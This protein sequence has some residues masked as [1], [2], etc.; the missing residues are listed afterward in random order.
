MQVDKKTEKLV[1]TT[2]ISRFEFQQSTASIVLILKVLSLQIEFKM[3]RFLSK[4]RPESR[5][6][7]KPIYRYRD[8]TPVSNMYEDYRL[9]GRSPVASRSSSYATAIETAAH[10]KRSEDL[11]IEF[12]RR[13]YQDRSLSSAVLVGRI[14]LSKLL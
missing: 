14:F 13:R 9:F 3:S 10:S 4:Y 2:H 6:I 5:P 12:S 8:Y 11:P 1:S 7:N